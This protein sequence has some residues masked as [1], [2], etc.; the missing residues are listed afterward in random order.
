MP[1]PVDTLEPQAVWKP[2]CGRGR[3][4][5]EESGQ[6]LRF[7]EVGLHGYSYLEDVH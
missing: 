7:Y 3:L 5:Y 2:R 6:L 1:T 4:T